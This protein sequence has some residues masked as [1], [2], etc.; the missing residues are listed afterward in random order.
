MAR[1][2]GKNGKV[3]LGSNFIGHL[4]SFDITEKADK[5][6]ATAAGEAWDSHIVTQKSWSGSLALRLDHASGAYQTPRAGDELAVEFYTDGDA[7]GKTL[8]SGTV[9]LDDHG[10][11]LSYDGEVGRKYSFTGNGELV[12]EVVA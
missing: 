1:H 12:V 6:K 7:V 11:D 2:S 5:V 4:V 10:I 8:L 3:K 9:I